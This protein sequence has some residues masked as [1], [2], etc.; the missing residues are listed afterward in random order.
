MLGLELATPFPGMR[1]EQ[2]ISIL[3]LCHLFFLF[4]GLFV[5]QAPATALL[6]LE[7]LKIPV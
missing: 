4:L 6:V 3:A 5:F 1:L 7:T 2:G